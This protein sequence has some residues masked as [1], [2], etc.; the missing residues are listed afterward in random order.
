MGATKVRDARS[1]VRGHGKAK[2]GDG[3][4]TAQSIGGA[5]D[6]EPNTLAGNETAADGTDDGH[7]SEE[8]PGQSHENSMGLPILVV[9]STLAQGHHFANALQ[10]ALFKG[11]GHTSSRA[12]IRKR[13]AAPDGPD[14]GVGTIGVD[15]N[16][17]VLI[18]E[19]SEE[20]FGLPIGLDD[21]GIEKGLGGIVDWNNGRLRALTEE[22]FGY[23]DVFVRKTQNGFG[24]GHESIC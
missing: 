18:E 12:M 23:G 10:G 17:T 3:Q 1:V 16:F 21:L 14:K 6:L 4:N 8:T 24:V 5:V 2:S 20:A 11:N 13:V 9:S 7:G 15:G 22:V 19:L